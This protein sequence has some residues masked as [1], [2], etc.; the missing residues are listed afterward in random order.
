MTDM[1]YAFTL[2]LIPLGSGHIL[3]RLENIPEYIK[4]LFNSLLGAGYISA[5]IS[6]P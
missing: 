3:I 6:I 1:L 5:T 2:Q 4:G